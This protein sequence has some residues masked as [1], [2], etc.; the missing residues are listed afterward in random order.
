MRA[1]SATDTAPAAVALAFRNLL[2]T[3]TT[4]SGKIEMVKPVIERRKP[5]VGS[6]ADTLR[7]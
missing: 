4:G 1:A 2:T 6:S 5:G 7:V 3:T